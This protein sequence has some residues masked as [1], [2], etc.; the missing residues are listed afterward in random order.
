MRA[1]PP[2]ALTLVLLLALPALAAGSGIQTIATAGGG[3]VPAFLDVAVG[4][5]DGDG[6][7][8]VL[9][10]AGD[11]WLRLSRW[12]MVGAGNN[13]TGWR[14][15][16]IP[17]P[18]AEFGIAV[19]TGDL[20]RDGRDEVYVG[21]GGQTSSDGHLFR[22]RWTGQAWNRTSLIDAGAI[23]IAVGD[24]DGIPGE[25]VYAAMWCCEV[26]WFKPSDS[27]HSGL[28]ARGEGPAWGLAVGDGDRDGRGEVYFTT[29]RNEV[30]QAKHLGGANWTDR[31]VGRGWQHG[32]NMTSVALGDANRDGL[33]DVYATSNDGGFYR[34]GWHGAGWNRE[35]AA[36]FS[37]SVTFGGGS[38]ADA[39]LGDR[40]GDRLQ[41]AYVAVGPRVYKV[42]RS[43]QGWSVSSLGPGPVDFYEEL[44][45]GSVRGAGVSILAA[46]KE[47][48][49]EYPG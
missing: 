32:R 28:A 13:S 10:V 23:R 12:S 47:R 9:S 1:R 29:E 7:N 31:L 11:R 48:L 6:R 21:T 38:P 40:N 30:R 41:E 15:G 24:G 16:L 39:L 4:D 8:E 42:F 2:L 14:T 17:L 33:V 36:N 25:E 45:M 22:F 26:A 49:V 35:M 3:V 43:Q 18:A 27:G 44:A 34:F 5:V 19:A 20:D 46:G 37:A